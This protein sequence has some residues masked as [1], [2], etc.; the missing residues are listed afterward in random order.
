M[1]AHHSSDYGPSR[2]DCYPPHT[3]LGDEC[4][5]ESKHKLSRTRALHLHP[6][7]TTL[8]RYPPPQE[9]P[10]AGITMPLAAPRSEAHPGELPQRLC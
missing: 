1:R 7:P 4:L 5:A 9:G 2:D 3:H 6:T 10:S 8:H